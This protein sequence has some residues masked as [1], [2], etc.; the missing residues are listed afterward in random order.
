MTTKGPAVEDTFRNAVLTNSSDNVP[1]SVYRNITQ[2]V[3]YSPYGW[4]LIT[5]IIVFV[6]L[7]TIN[8]PFVQCNQPDNSM[9]KPPPNATVI[10]I[11]SLISAITVI[12][13]TKLI[14]PASAS[15]S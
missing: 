15:T 8:P 4:A 13:C 3:M 14:K 12:G 11:L 10:F 5:F 2:K 6:F 7:Y 9:S 1:G